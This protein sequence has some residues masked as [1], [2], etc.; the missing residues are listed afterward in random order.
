MK[1]ESAVLVNYITIENPFSGLFKTQVL[2]VLRYSSASSKAAITLCVIIYPWTYILKRR[3]LDSLRKDCEKNGISV[4]FLPFLFPVKYMLKSVLVF[5]IGFWWLALVGRLYPYSNIDHCRGY[6]TTFSVLRNRPQS[7]VIFDMRSAWIDENIAAA[8]LVDDGALHRCWRD[9][10]K[11][12]L[13]NS[14]AVLGVSDSMSEIATRGPAKNYH[15]IPIAVDERAL[16]FCR[17][18]RQTLRAKWNWTNSLVAVYS[19]SLGLNGIGKDALSDLFFL[20]AKS[21]PA[22]KFLILTNERPEIVYSLLANA[23]IDLRLARVLSV[24]PEALGDYLSVA[25]FGIHALPQQLDSATRLGTKVVE[26]WMNGL[27]TVV[28]P[29]VGA[30]AKIVAENGVGY[31]VSPAD[32]FSEDDRG[33][34]LVSQFAREYYQDAFEDFD[35]RQFDVR[36]I[37][38]R[39]VKLYC[40]D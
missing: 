31:V 11:Y 22:L 6:F 25:D 16:R 29:T 5:R 13:R 1:A 40:G 26:Y 36:N 7:R 18:S 33:R 35:I 9:L 19:G 8:G 14:Y 39:H 34:L 24:A 30:A 21:H 28:T 15:T 12:C 2:N 4:V 3:G 23:S 27:P 32:Q 10:E 20:L 38:A 17:N 37:S